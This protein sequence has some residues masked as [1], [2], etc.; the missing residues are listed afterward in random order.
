MWQK[1]KNGMCG[2]LDVRKKREEE[3]DGGQNVAKGECALLSLMPHAR[4]LAQID[5]ALMC[6]EA[7]VNAS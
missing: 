6:P 2:C 4:D 1:A 5:Y 3:K 7:I